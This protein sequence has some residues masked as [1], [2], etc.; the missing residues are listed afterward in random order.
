MTFYYANYTSEGIG[1]VDY[2]A[3]IE[4]A[5]RLY[6]NHEC[7]KVSEN[8]FKKMKRLKVPYFPVSGDFQEII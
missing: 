1:N 7:L 2:E 8:S 6:I 5:K 3:I 4:S